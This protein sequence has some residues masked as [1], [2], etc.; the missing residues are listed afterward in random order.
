MVT[1]KLNEMK[2]AGM[3]AINA[4]KKKLTDAQAPFNRAAKKVADARAKVN[5]ICRGE[6][7]ISID[8]A[9]QLG[10]KAEVDEFLA[11]RKHAARKIARRRLLSAKTATLSEVIDADLT[12]DM[13]ASAQT[14]AK[15]QTE[16]IS[17]AAFAE[18]EAVQTKAKW[19]GRRRRWHAH[20]P[21]PHIP[22]RHH[23]HVPHRHR[24]HLHHRHRPHL[25]VPHIHTAAMIKAAKDAARRAAAAA[26]KA[27]RDAAARAAK[28]ARDA[29]C[30]AA[31]GV[32]KAAL[33]VAEQAV[34]LPARVL[35]AAKL[36][37]KGVLAAQ[38]AAFAIMKGALNILPAVTYLKFSLTLMVVI[39]AAFD[40]HIKF[41]AMG[42]NF[43]LRLKLNLRD[44]AAMVFF[45]HLV[46]RT[47]INE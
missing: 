4:A 21:H 17:D 47:V 46:N 45:C 11:S 2:Q 24:P 44:L 9:L 5:G 23:I 16:Q 43:D 41:K 29:A 6:E 20:I 30:A 36:A 28:A 22:H 26:A 13:R 15:A 7:M 42:K 3:R 18:D 32:A 39:P 31:K 12:E 37:L 8:E 34:R 27:A 38:H 10:L 25:H 35:D 33:H 1:A 19:G 14:H 40:F